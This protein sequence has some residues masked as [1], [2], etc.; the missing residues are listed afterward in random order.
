MP[1]YAALPLLLP[2]PGEQALKVRFSLSFIPL[3]PQAFQAP[4]SPMAAHQHPCCQ[5]PAAS[6]KTCNRPQ[7]SSP[8]AVSSPSGPITT[9]KA[10]AARQPSGWC[11]WGC[12]WIAP[13]MG[14][15]AAAAAQCWQ[16]SRV[17]DQPPLQQQE[18]QELDQGQEQRWWQ[19]GTA[20]CAECCQ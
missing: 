11:R 4:L 19:Q 9:P 5:T 18:R 16:V 12:W 3:A 14:A 10:Q 2:E 13:Q 8:P 17:G 1:C 6:P 7:V 15:A 20:A